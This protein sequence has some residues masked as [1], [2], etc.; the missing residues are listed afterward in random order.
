MV[1]SSTFSW[2]FPT[3]Q[4]PT[5]SLHKTV[6]ESHT[7][8]GVKAAEFLLRNLYVDDGLTSVPS[9]PEAI[10]LVKDSQALCAPASLPLHRFATNSKEVL[11]G[12]P[13]ND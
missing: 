5:I 8:F 10:K 12:L 13:Q 7:Q 11:E 2:L 1:P 3:W 4:L 6:E 9:V